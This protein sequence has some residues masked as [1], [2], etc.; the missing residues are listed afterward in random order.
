MSKCVRCSCLNS[1]VPQNEIVEVFIVFLLLL[2]QCQFSELL[3]C[4]FCM[5]VRI[6]AF[7]GDVGPEFKVS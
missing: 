6:C 2:L 5:C 1:V 4:I 3:E 7:Q